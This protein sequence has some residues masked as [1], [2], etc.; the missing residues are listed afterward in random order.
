MRT[1]SVTQSLSRWCV[2]VWL[3][4]AYD[5]FFCFLHVRLTWAP[6]AARGDSRLTIPDATLVYWVSSWHIISHVYIHIQFFWR[7]SI[8]SHCKFVGRCVCVLECHSNE[9]SVNGVGSYICAVRSSLADEDCLSHFVGQRLVTSLRFHLLAWILSS[10]TWG[11]FV[12]IP[13]SI[14]HII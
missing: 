10:H 14:F 4:A 13:H 3:F 12:C 5:V 6:L 2:F 9:L 11:C 1:Q 8:I 7:I